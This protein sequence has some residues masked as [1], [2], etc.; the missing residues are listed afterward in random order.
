MRQP[1]VQSDDVVLTNFFESTLL[2]SFRE[3]TGNGASQA[4][5]R[6]H[7]SSTGAS[8]AAGR[9]PLHMAMSV[10]RVHYQPPRLSAAP[11][12]LERVPSDFSHAAYAAR[13]LY[14]L[15]LFSRRIRNRHAKLDPRLELSALPLHRERRLLRADHFYFHT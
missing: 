7:F 12:E 3:A 11:F 13:G 4:I 6:L 15:P 1:T 14:H 10:I 9:G 5:A 8:R 2:L